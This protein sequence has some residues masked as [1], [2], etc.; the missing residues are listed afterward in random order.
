[1]F[2]TSAEIAELTGIA[3]G[4]HGQTREQLQAAQLREM[5][6]AFRINAKGRPVITWDAVNGLSAKAEPSNVWRSNILKFG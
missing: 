2:L 5:G 1:M 6:V 3:R 4:R